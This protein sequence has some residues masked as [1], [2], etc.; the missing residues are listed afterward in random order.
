MALRGDSKRRK[1]K[2]RP[3]RIAPTRIWTTARKEVPQTNINTLPNQGHRGRG[4]R[5]KRNPGNN[6][7]IH[8]KYN[9]T[10]T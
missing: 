7:L 8:R 1:G 10:T 4:S 6:A 9:Q 3:I 2:I 5:Q